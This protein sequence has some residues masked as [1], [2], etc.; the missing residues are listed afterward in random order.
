M[1]DIKQGA[2][3]FWGGPAHGNITVCSGP[4]VCIP[5]FDYCL[6]FDEDTISSVPYTV[7]NYRMERFMWKWKEEWHIG[8]AMVAA[9]SS[10]LEIEYL[11][12]FL[13][14]LFGGNC[15]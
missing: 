11:L 9:D 8:K 1:K 13:G 10:V 4:K 14:G 5:V 3:P 15:D 12:D 2:I 7:V 6:K